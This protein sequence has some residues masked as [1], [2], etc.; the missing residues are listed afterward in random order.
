[1]Q[2]LAGDIGGTKTLLAICEVSEASE[3]TGAPGIEVEASKPY[4]SG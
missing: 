3:R 1:M 2:V 4:E